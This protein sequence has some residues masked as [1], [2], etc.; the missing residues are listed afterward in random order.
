ETSLVESE[1]ENWLNAGCGGPPQLCIEIACNP[2]PAAC[3]PDS[4]GATTGTCVQ[5]LAGADGGA[6]PD[7]GES[8]DQ[9]AADYSAAVAAALLCTPGAPNQC[10][11]AA[12]PM[13][14][15]CNDSC[16]THISVNDASAVNAARM[17]WV[18]QC[19]GDYGCPLS[20]CE[21]PAPTGTCVPAGND[22]GAGT[23]VTGGPVTTY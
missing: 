15:P 20:I 7:A 2:P 11:A 13:L 4:L 18:A 6:A 21:L 10:Q 3:V 12:D 23:C 5:F 1:R 19:A 16:G 8:C 22:A 14:T 9:L 17:R